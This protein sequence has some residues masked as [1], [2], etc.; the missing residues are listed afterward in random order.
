MAKEKDILMFSSEIRLY[1][2]NEF[3]DILKVTITPE[4]TVSI[5]ID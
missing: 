1:D 4:D 3:E 5:N 2:E